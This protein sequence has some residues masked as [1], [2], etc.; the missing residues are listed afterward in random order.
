MSIREMGGMRFGPLSDAE[1]RQNEYLE[2][3]NHAPYFT[4]FMVMG[5]LFCL[6]T[7]VLL[8]SAF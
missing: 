2:S 5:G 4:I 1:R 3:I 6:F 8:L 7:L